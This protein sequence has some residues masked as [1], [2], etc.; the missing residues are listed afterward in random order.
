[1]P[2]HLGPVQLSDWA[3]TLDF[4]PNFA[5]RWPQTGTDTVWPESGDRFGADHHLGSL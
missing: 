3:A 5:P 1:M 4:G 2:T